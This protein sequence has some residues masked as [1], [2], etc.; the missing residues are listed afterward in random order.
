[1]IPIM[2]EHLFDQYKK[3]LM[4]CIIS[5]KEEFQIYGY[6][7]VTIDEIWN[8][9]KLKIWKKNYED[10]KI[11][12]LVN[13]ILTVSISDYM[14]FIQIEAYKTPNVFQNEGMDALKSLL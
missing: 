7:E 8:F 4:P 12:Q 10:K 11:H 9:L 13:D 6:Q 2:T 1:M 3:Q 5:K 14:N